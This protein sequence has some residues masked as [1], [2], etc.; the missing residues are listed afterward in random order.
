MAI[1]LTQTAF[2]PVTG[3]FGSGNVQIFGGTGTTNATYTWTIPPGVG[4][5][6]ARVFGGG[7]GGTSDNVPSV[8][9][10]EQTSKFVKLNLL[11]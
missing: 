3:V 2:N 10:C 7:G 8:L 6:R 4:K 9:T 11:L 1:A 5:V